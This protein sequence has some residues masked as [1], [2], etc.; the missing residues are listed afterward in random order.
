A[1]YAG[2]SP[3]LSDGMLFSIGGDQKV[4]AF[5]D[6]LVSPVADFSAEP[7]SGDAPLT[8]NFTD[9]STGSPTSWSWE[10]G[11]GTNVTDQKASHTY[12]EAGS[13][14]VSLTV[15]NAGG[16][17][18]E[19]KTD[20][21][22]VSN[23]EVTDTTNPVIDSAVLFPA[24]TT[25]GSKINIA[26][27]ATDNKEVTEVTAGNITLVKDSDGVWQGS[28]TAP[29]SVGSYSLSIK[30]KDTAGNTAESSVPYRV[31]QRSGGANIAASPRSSSVAAGG[32]V[33]LAIKV[34]NTQN[35]DD[36]FK[37]R[38]SVSE[39]PSAYQANT[40]WFDWTEKTVTLKAGQEVLIPIKVNVPE[41][42]AAGRK[43]F[44][45]YVNSETAALTGYDTGYLVIS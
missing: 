18:S 24:N 17:D 12:T 27:N 10:F 26:V 30:A 34:K 20:Y 32:N 8:V 7:I 2:S 6:S 37:V 13:Y 1:P 14:T 43:L 29:S 42:T 45:A 41:G 39:L 5:K 31:L 28:I 22:V 9:Q 33:S 40:S 36:T 19:T 15:S 16:S 25:A 3:A 38:V 4:Y 11:D 35:I 44:R 21:I 23:P